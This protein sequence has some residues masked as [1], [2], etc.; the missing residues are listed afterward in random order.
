MPRETYIQNQN[1]VLALSV[2][3][4]TRKIKELGYL[5]KKLNLS[6]LDQ[7]KKIIAPSPQNNKLHLIRKS[8]TRLIIQLIKIKII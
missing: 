4:L 1:K 7:G 2:L 5:H 8:I 6:R 3:K